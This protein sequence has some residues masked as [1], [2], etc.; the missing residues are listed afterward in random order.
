MK[1]T[2]SFTFI[3]LIALS[4][5]LSPTHKEEQLNNPICSNPP[6]WKGLVYQEDLP[7]PKNYY[8]LNE[9]FF[10][11]NGFAFVKQEFTNAYRYWTN[12]ELEIPC[13]KQF[14]ADDIKLEWRGKSNLSIGLAESDMGATITGEKEMAQI[15]CITYNRPP[16]FK[17]RYGTKSLTNVPEL[18]N[19][20]SEWATY[21]ISVKNK[22]MG[23]YKNDRLVKEMNDNQV[24]GQLKKISIHFKGSGKVDWVRL[25][26][27]DKLV[28]Q[29]TFNQEEKS[30][31][32]WK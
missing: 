25:Y 1:Q 31:V 15:N 22:T 12:I 29:E 9:E 7:G 13:A 6:K 14:S 28:M 24:L 27:K 19:N 23:F 10:I 4:I 16:F 21:A 18:V 8:I 32:E 30:S 11:H 20:P 5:F 3:S 26:H 2:L 17:F